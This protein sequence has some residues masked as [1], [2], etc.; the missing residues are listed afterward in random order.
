MSVNT[1]LDGIASSLIT[2]GNEKDSID[3]SFS[4]FSG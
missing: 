1:Y 4:V 3:R 2:K